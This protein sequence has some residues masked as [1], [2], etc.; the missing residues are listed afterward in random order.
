MA[1]LFRNAVR[2]TQ[3]QRDEGCAGW[4]DTQLVEHRMHELVLWHPLAALDEI[5]QAGMHTDLGGDLPLRFA[6][7]DAREP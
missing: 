6:N 1:Y 2:F 4:V 5:E 3:H 7:R